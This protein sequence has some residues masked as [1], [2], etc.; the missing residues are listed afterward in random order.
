MVIVL[1]TPPP[2]HAANRMRLSSN[3]CNEYNSGNFDDDSIRQCELEMF[4]QRYEG[5][6]LYSRM[7]R[8]WTAL[9]MAATRTCFSESECVE[10]SSILFCPHVLHHIFSRLENIFYGRRKFV[11]VS[12]FQFGCDLMWA[13]SLCGDDFIAF[14]HRI[15]RFSNLDSSFA[16]HKFVLCAECALM[17]VCVSC[18]GLSAHSKDFFT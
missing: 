10:H 18:A 9:S 12:Y 17:C 11:L 4:F 7:I 13:V 15:F 8:G 3:E 16:S 5:L 6:G 14:S 2:R 1:L